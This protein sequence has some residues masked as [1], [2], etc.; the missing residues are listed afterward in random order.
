MTTST[1]FLTSRA[2]FLDDVKE[3][4][5]PFFDTN[6]LG[7][8]LN[9]DVDITI[10][11]SLTS[12]KRRENGLTCSS[13]RTTHNFA[14]L[15]GYLWPGASAYQWNSALPDLGCFLPSHEHPTE[16]PLPDNSHFS[17]VDIS[18]LIGPHGTSLLNPWA[19]IGSPTDSRIRL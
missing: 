17:H 9:S 2:A 1:F 3:W 11:L 6:Q 8:M 18:A 15:G 14:G 13:F 19:L 4:S 10:L 5:G 16:P 7:V 12:T